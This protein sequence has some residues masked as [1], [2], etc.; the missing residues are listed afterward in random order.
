MFLLFG[1]LASFPAYA[2]LPSEVLKDPVLEGRARALSEELR[3]LVC[4]NESIDD[5]AA[6]LAADLR[7]LLRQRITAGDTDAQV[8]DFLVARYG[9]FILLKP[10]FNWHTALLWAAPPGVLL[11]GFAIAAVGYRRR[12]IGPVAPLRPSEE[13]ALRRLLSEDKPNITES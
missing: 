11:I 7:V 13:E 5:S 4:Q 10:R 12:R 9:E 8:L 1:L 2:V 6:P 3:C